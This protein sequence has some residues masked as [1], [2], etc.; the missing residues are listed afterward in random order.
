MTSPIL[1]LGIAATLAWLLPTALAGE[2]LKEGTWS[3]TWVN[4]GGRNRRPRNVSI[5][6]KNT[7]DPH[8]RWR[9]GQGELMTATFAGLGGQQR[10]ALSD[11]RL[12]NGVLS[13]SLQREDIR[14][15]CRLNLGE[16]GA[17]KGD[18]TGGDGQR[19]HLT[20]TPPEPS[21]AQ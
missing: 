9:T 15:S 10:F 12:E 2:R 18:C 6:V 20:L 21:P 8:W 1:H 19:S 14:V 5:E 7:P 17:Y 3:G 4:A 16:E 11:I 13:Y